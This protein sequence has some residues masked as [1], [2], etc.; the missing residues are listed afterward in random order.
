MFHTGLSNLTCHITSDF[1]Y[2]DKA[3]SFNHQSWNVRT[4]GDIAPLFQR[5][6]IEANRGF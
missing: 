3:T 1:G 4:R 6:D 2:F 5:F